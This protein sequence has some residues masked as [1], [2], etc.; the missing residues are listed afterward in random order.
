MAREAV[1]AVLW[2]PHRRGARRPA[3]VE[4]ADALKVL[5]DPARLRLL[6]LVASAADGES[7]ACDWSSHSSAHSRPSRTTSRCSSTPASSPRTRGKWAY[8]Q[9]DRE[10]L[11]ALC[12]VLCP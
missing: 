1:R 5:A 7:C 11:R 2:N 9:V 6:S 8:Y 12:A 3:A 4:L 10:R